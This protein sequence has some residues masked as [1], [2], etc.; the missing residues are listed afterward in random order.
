MQE[1]TPILEFKAKE[2][3]VYLVLAISF[4]VLLPILA[5]YFFEPSDN[6]QRYIQLDI[7]HGIAF[8]FSIAILRLLYYIFFQGKVIQI[9]KTFIS[10]DHKR[11]DWNA[12]LYWQLST[13]S[14]GKELFIQLKGNDLILKNPGEAIIS[15]LPADKSLELQKNQKELKDETKAQ[16]IKRFWL[17]IIFLTICLS[18]TWICTMIKDH[19]PADKISINA[20]LLETPECVQHIPRKSS[21]Y[22]Y[23]VS[24]PL[25]GIEEF[26]V[27][28]ESDT[29]IENINGNLWKG[30]TISIQ[31]LKYDYD[32]KIAK[33]KAPSF[34]DKHFDWNNITIYGLSKG[35]RIIIPF[36]T[37]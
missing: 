11:Y 14:T 19:K 32:I 18:S 25:K 33:T 23:H 20:I 36:E 17:W 12:V 9:Y 13:T 35:S 4:A 8:F 15:L 34:W 31:V 7:A 1:E 3:E 21:R 6:K 5:I 10:I 2:F 30:D 29:F 28:K 27:Y 22:Y 24:L 37:K 16:E 26:N